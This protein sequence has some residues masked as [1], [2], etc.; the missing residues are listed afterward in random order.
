[1][2]SI[3]RN[4]IEKYPLGLL[5]VMTVAVVSSALVFLRGDRQTGDV[6]MWVFNAEHRDLFLPVA[7]RWNEDPESPTVDV[8][9]L[10]FQSLSRRML[11]GFFSGT[12]MA[13]LIMGE[14]QV[15]SQAWRG[16]VEAIGFVDIT[17]RLEA[18]DLRQRF[19]PPSFAPWTVNGRIY[20]LPMDVHPVMLAYRA[21]LYEA[22]G[23]PI[24]EARTWREF[25]EMSLPLIGDLTGN[26]VQDRFVLE[27]PEADGN[28]ATMLILQAG[29]DLFDANGQPGM[30]HPV[31]VEV[32]TELVYWSSRRPALTVDIPLFTGSGER[33]RGEGIVLA[34]LVPDW[35]AGRTMRNI[36]ALSGK[37]KLMPLPPWEEGGLRTSVWGGTMIGFARASPNFENTWRFAT[38]LVFDRDVARNMWREMM[39]ISPVVDFWDDPVYDEPLEYYSGQAIGRLLVEMAGDVPYRSSSVYYTL[40]VTEL[41]NAL[42][43]LNRE[44]RRMASPPDRETI[45]AMVER[46]LAV[47]QENVLRIVE[48]NIFQAPQ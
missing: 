14:R 21:D 35:R 12:P 29:G 47:A 42:N 33:L 27:M 19:N 38:D 28:V 23:I 34:W 26:G 20:G 15:A 36:P 32:M 6:E 10:E 11:S 13:D 43:R 37:M 18:E 2:G 31:N 30:V 25:M 48:R 24:E 44:A 22:A 5:V 4:I 7:D 3:G 17:D 1:M 46:D 40:A 45:R 41:A 39:I 16:P 9:L 8:L